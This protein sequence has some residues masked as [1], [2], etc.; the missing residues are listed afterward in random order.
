MAEPKNAVLIGLGMVSGTHLAALADLGDSVRLYGVL[1][2]SPER[3]SSF[4]AKASEFGITPRTYRDVAEV[5]ADGA[6]DLAI[7]VTPPNARLAFVEPLSKAGI[8]IL[9]EKPVERTTEAA[10]R[11]VALCESRGVPLGI[12]FQ[13][14]MRA[15]VQMLASV[16]AE[17]GLGEIGLVEISVPWWRDQAYYDE[18]GRGTYERDGGGV[19][20]SQA[21]HTLDLAL[22][23]VGPVRQVQAMARRTAFHDMESED[24][25]AAGLDFESGAVGS[26]VASTAS[27]PGGPESITLHGTLGSAV[28]IS[29]KVTLTMRSGEVEEFGEDAGTGGGADPMAFTH[30]WHRDIIADFASAIDEGRPPLVTGREALRVHALIDALILSSKTGQAQPVAKEG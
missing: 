24:F 30:G 25:V 13:L 8:P 11:M 15:A 9:M 23:L 6:V 7:V 19:L 17:G 18:P 4:L 3:L 27:Y 29:G 16:L 12:V 26:L 1:G 14:R 5:A 22:S 21:I 28:M 2:R 20:I 10:E